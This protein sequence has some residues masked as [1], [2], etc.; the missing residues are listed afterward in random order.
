MRALQKF[1][2]P[3]AIPKDGVGVGGGEEGVGG[4][5]GEKEGGRES[6]SYKRLEFTK[7][8]IQLKVRYPKYLMTLNSNAT[9]S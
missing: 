1:G 5:G 9:D 7:S 3:F 6:T 8:L 2:E 4:R